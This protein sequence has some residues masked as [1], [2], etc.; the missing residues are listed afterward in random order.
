MLRVDT[1]M[2]CHHIFCHQATKDNLHR[3][4]NGLLWPM[5]PGFILD[6]CSSIRHHSRQ[7]QG[8]GLDASQISS[9]PSIFDLKSEML[10]IT[11]CCG[12]FLTWGILHKIVTVYGLRNCSKSGYFGTTRNPCSTPEAPTDARSIQQN[13]RSRDRC[14]QHVSSQKSGNWNNWNHWNLLELAAFLTLDVAHFWASTLN[15]WRKFDT[16]RSQATQYGTARLLYPHPNTLFRLLYH[17]YFPCFTF[18]IKSGFR[19]FNQKH[20]EDTQIR[21]EF[22]NHQ[23]KLHFKAACLYS[24]NISKNMSGMSQISLFGENESK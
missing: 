9:D 17:R 24:K 16:E 13:H 14:P 15:L 18:Q 1:A 19:G 5:V 6:L 22:R 2:R 7:S 20:Q 21:V 8:N 12:C 11:K 10:H 23:H 3:S 4:P